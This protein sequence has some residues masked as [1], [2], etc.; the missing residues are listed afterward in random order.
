VRYKG[1]VNHN[2]QWVGSYVA[3]Y[4]V[5]IL[6]KKAMAR[7]EIW[8]RVRERFEAEGIPLV[9]ANFAEGAPAVM[10]KPAALADAGA[11]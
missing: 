4:R 6:P 7:E 11:A 2:G 3:G 10:I 8:N 9:P 5:K 1:V